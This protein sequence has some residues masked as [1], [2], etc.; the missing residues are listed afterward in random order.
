MY[1]TMRVRTVDITLAT[2]AVVMSKLCRQYRQEVL[3]SQKKYHP[4]KPVNLNTPRGPH[5][6]DLCCPDAWMLTGDQGQQVL[7]QFTG[8]M[9]TAQMALDV[10]EI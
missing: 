8:N 6:D 2:A 10:L 3:S 7:Q 9:E 4:N 1:R 5:F